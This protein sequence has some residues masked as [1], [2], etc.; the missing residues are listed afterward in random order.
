MYSLSSI[1]STDSRDPSLADQR[2][3]GA[4]W[5]MSRKLGLITMLGSQIKLNIPLK[6][7]VCS[8]LFQARTFRARNYFLPTPSYF[9]FPASFDLRET[10][11]R[12]WSH[13]M[14]SI[15]ESQVHRPFSADLR[16]LARSPQGEKL[17]DF[18][19]PIFR[20]QVGITDVSRNSLFK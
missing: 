19:S 15:V 9:S 17:R 3:Q 5:Y 10:S 11:T 1:E 4:L 18:Y 8:A 20:S 14:I 12:S 16:S 13:A 7:D 6:S 2:G